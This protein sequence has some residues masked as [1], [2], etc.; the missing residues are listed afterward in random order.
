MDPE[1]E[2]RAVEDR[3][4]ELE[5]DLAPFPER[6]DG[7][8]GGAEGIVGASE[9]RRGGVGLAPVFGAGR[10][11][12]DRF[13]VDGGPAGLWR[14]EN[15]EECAERDPQIRHDACLLLSSGPVQVFWLPGHP[16]RRAFPDPVGSS[17]IVRRPS[18]VTAARPRGIHTLFPRHGP[19]SVVSRSFAAGGG[20]CQ[21]RLTPPRRRWYE[22]LRL[23]CPCGQE[24]RP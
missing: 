23:R 9:A 17:G 11:R 5:R 14:E 12:I 13:A 2:A 20:P 22:S 1:V 4:P 8:I 3:E 19:Y 24:G 7:R 10:E 21:A 18:P 6:D 16:V 15:D